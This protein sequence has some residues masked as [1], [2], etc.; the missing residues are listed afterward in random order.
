MIDPP[1]AP[2]PSPEDI[3]A[4]A[5]DPQTATLYAMVSAAVQSGADPADV[6]PAIEQELESE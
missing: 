6:M 3:A 2:A 4:V 1:A 5:P